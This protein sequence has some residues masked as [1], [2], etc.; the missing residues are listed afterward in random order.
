MLYLEA[1]RDCKIMPSRIV[2]IGPFPAPIGG[3]SIHIR[4]LATLLGQSGIVISGI[5]ESPLIKDE[6]YNI[7]SRRVIGYVRLIRSAD[8]I[9]IHSSVDM[10]RVFH[11]LAGFIFRKKIVVTLHS[12]RGRGKLITLLQGFIFRRIS[13]LI[14][15][16]EA[17]GSMFN[18]PN[19]IVKP[20][21]LPPDMSTEERLPDYVVDWVDSHRKAGAFIIASNAFRLDRYQGLDL[22]GADMCIDLMSYLEGTDDRSAALVFVVASLDRSQGI[23]DDYCKKIENLGLKEKIL[24]I[25]EK[26]LS[27]ARL[28]QSSDI[29]LRAT[30]T[31]GDA[32]S[33][34][35]SLHL[36]RPVIASDVVPRPPGTSLFRSRDQDDF[37]RTVYRVLG[38]VESKN[39]NHDLAK[40]EEYTKF[41]NSLYKNVV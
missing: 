1:A 35:E 31:D 20:A 33:I 13:K 2:L 24:F 6:I 15:V 19:M 25:H 30:N 21:F 34:R 27:F 29:T 39:N 11:M 7:R 28:I 12:W 14:C 40:A 26:N 23:F 36:A 16:N 18:Y 8:I 38:E 32:L 4:R 37:N 5:D 3:V 17:I 10:L 9:H 22:Y 41:Y